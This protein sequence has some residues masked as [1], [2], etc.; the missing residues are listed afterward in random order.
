MTLAM[1]DGTIRGLLLLGQNPVVG[2]QQQHA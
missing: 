2:G 1:D